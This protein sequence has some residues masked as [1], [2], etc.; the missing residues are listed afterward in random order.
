MIEEK[1]Q[2]LKL[3]NEAEYNNETLIK[4][5]RNGYILE[6]LYD[7]KDF[8]YNNNIKNYN[9]ISKELFDKYLNIE[10]KKLFCD[11]E[12]YS[13][14]IHFSQEKHTCEKCGYFEYKT[15][16]YNRVIYFDDYAQ[17][18]ENVA[19]NK[20]YIVLEEKYFEKFKDHVEQIL[21]ENNFGEKQWYDYNKY[22]IYFHRLTNHYIKCL[23]NNDKNLTYGKLYELCDRKDREYL[24]FFDDS[25]EYRG[26]KK[27]NYM[28][29]EKNFEIIKNKVNDI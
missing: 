25:G 20:E 6:F 4:L 7:S 9:E 3:L 10:R 1:E 5:L 19:N 26:M 27:I 15:V 17:K 22:S 28:G 24:Y 14:H 16:K 13:T 2:Y 12:F 8:L 18:Y 11:H 29:G 21:I 23:I